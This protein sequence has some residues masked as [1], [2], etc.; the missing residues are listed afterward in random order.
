MIRKFFTY[1]F[2]VVIVLGAGYGYYDY[3]QR[4]R[5]DCYIVE[6]VTVRPGDTYWSIVTDA[7]ERHNAPNVDIRRVID[8][9]R[10]LNGG[11]ADLDV[12]AVVTIRIPKQFH[13]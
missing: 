4:T 9:C 13:D 3:E 6:D 2:A 10:Q 8:D 1:L 7:M 12:G 5:V 11:K